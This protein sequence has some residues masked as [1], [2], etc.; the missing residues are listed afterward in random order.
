MCRWGPRTSLEKKNTFLFYL[1]EVLK[2][3]SHYP[4]KIMSEG[5]MQ[6][7]PWSHSETSQK[8]T[9]EDPSSHPETAGRRLSIPL[10]ARTSEWGESVSRSLVPFRRVP[11]AAADSAT[12]KGSPRVPAG[13]LPTSRWSVRH[14]RGASPRWAQPPS[15]PLA[16]PQPPPAGAHRRGPHLSS[17]SLHFTCKGTRSW[18]RTWLMSDL[19]PDGCAKKPSKPGP[20]CQF[21]RS[22]R[23]DRVWVWRSA[24][25]EEEEE[26]DKHR[27][28]RRFGPRQPPSTPSGSGARTRAVIAYF[29]SLT[30][31]VGRT[32]THTAPRRP[33]LLKAGDQSD[34]LG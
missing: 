26:N 11:S 7:L 23:P 4:K 13:F 3:H 14:G 5:L 33:C 8:L 27:E 17:Q 22:P 32:H 24:P 25:A 19:C 29:R 28:R 1:V 34:G 30:S 16:R 15:S 2:L 18:N 9:A 12:H 31:E 6:T 20:Q 21:V 10:R